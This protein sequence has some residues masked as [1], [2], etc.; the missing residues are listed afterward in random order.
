MTT[1]KVYFGKSCDYL[2]ECFCGNINSTSCTI[3]ESSYYYC[4][5]CKIAYEVCIGDE[6][7]ERIVEFKS[8]SDTFKKW[9]KERPDYIDTV[10]GTGS[11]SITLTILQVIS[12]YRNRTCGVCG[13]L[14]E[15]SGY[16]LIQ[17]NVNHVDEKWNRYLD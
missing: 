6:E 5:N 4:K 9:E 16:G 10:T 12:D 1:C 2:C 17:Y 15:W 8:D 13:V 11:R 3:H 14:S 7:C